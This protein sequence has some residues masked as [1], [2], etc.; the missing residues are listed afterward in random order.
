MWHLPFSA[1]WYI[2]DSSRTGPY[3]CELFGKPSPFRIRPA[4][5]IDAQPGNC[6]T[7]YRRRPRGGG[8]LYRNP[9]C[10]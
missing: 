5:L 2:C 10:P 3:L 7:G 8:I 6:H 1:A 4:E 9:V